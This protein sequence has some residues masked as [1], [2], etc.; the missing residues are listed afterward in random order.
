MNGQPITVVITKVVFEIMHASVR[1][2]KD[3]LEILTIGLQ[4]LIERA[5]LRRELPAVRAPIRREIQCNNFAV[6]SIG[7]SYCTRLGDKR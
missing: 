7:W 4:S 1:R 5:E 2:N 6:D 3:H